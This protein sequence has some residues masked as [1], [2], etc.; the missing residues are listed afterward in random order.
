MRVGN[1]PG[2][3]VKHER[4]GVTVYYDRVYAVYDTVHNITT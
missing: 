2:E 3:S 4:D 1:P